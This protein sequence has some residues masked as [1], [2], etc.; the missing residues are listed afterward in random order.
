VVQN[1][2]AGFEVLTAVIMKSYIFWD[3]K[4]YNPLEVNGS[5]RGT[6]L[7]HFEV[8]RINQARKLHGTHNKKSVVPVV[9]VEGVAIFYVAEDKTLQEYLCK[10]YEHHH[11]SLNY[12]I[13]AIIGNRERLVRDFLNCKALLIPMFLPK[14]AQITIYYTNFSNIVFS[15]TA[16][17]LSYR[18]FSF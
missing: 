15:A 16:H 2:C 1:I 18:N 4:P 10:C 12:L 7:L 13:N 5:F 6:F 9:D 14:S 3:I 17:A 8:Q 11:S